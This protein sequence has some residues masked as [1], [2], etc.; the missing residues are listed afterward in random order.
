MPLNTALRKTFFLPN[1][2]STPGGQT[3]RISQTS[4]ATARITISA[5]AGWRSMK[6][7][8]PAAPPPG[9]RL[10]STQ[11]AAQTHHTRL[12][13]SPSTLILPTL[14]TVFGSH[15]MHPNGGAR[16][17]FDRQYLLSVRNAPSGAQDLGSTAIIGGRHPNM[18]GKEAGERA[19]RGEA[20]I[21]ADIGDR[22]FRGDE[23][24]ERVLHDQR[25][26]IEMGRHAGLGTEQPVEV[27]TR[28]PGLACDR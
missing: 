11:T 12:H 28:Q 24:V 25:V 19:L 4:N 22:R 7:V 26:E 21:E 27:W 16:E 18:G 15:S 20:E 5:H 2:S 13:A 1:A 6:R 17:G 3:A 14:A 10:V 8:T 9:R 23:R